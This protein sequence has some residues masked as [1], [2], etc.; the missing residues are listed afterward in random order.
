MS[1]QIPQQVDRNDDLRRELEPKIDAK[2]P[3]VFFYWTIPIIVGAMSAL[4][5]VLFSMINGV[6]E[7]QNSKFDDLQKRMTVLETKFEYQPASKSR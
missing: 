3:C 2:L 4:L 5:F 6:Q 7:K 1:E